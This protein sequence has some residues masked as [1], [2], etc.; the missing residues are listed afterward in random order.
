MAP[1]AGQ[2]VGRWKVVRGPA[3]ERG[4]RAVGDHIA[5]LLVG[6][7]CVQAAARGSRASMLLSSGPA[8]ASGRV[9]ELAKALDC[10]QRAA[11]GRC[12]P[13]EERRRSVTRACLALP[14]DDANLTRLQVAAVRRC[15]ARDAVDDIGAACGH[16]AELAGACPMCGS[17][18][19]RAAR[20]HSGAKASPRRVASP[21]RSGWR[22]PR[23][24]GR[25]RTPRAQLWCDGIGYP[26]GLP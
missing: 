13:S 21:G 6:L 22:G 19:V 20:P 3:Q 5:E 1:P 25:W 18:L 15:A 16:L 9:S 24:S 11:G 17:P 12:A 26:C 8:G 4:P 10:V 2:R 23:A 14:V 7:T